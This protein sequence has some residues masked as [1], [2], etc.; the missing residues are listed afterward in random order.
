MLVA[1]MNP[2]PC[3]YLTH[4][5]IECVCSESSIKKYLSKIGGPI[6]DRI[7]IYVDVPKIDY[8][9]LVSK[10][11]EKEKSADIKKRV[12]AS[13]KIQ[14]E[15]YKKSKTTSNA[16]M[17]KSEMN[18]YCE[19]DSESKK[20]LLLAT[21]KLKLSGRGFDRIMK[22]SRTIADM[23]NSE[24]IHEEHIME[25]LQYRKPLF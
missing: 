17:T 10:S 21:E 11:K 1:A 23:D 25:A 19:I 9:E 7:D 22:I 12:Q 8:S 15:R 6:I 20:L 16:A 4:P 14:N 2:C 13:R 24:N 18:K 5:D 3:G